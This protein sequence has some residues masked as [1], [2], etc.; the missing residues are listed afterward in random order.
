VTIRG[1]VLTPDGSPAAGATLYLMRPGKRM[2]DVSPPEKVA[3]T[4]AAGRFEITANGPSASVFGKLIAVADGHALE[5]A[6][7]LSPPAGELT[8]KLAADLPIRGRLLD[9]EGRPVAGAT[10]R[11]RSVD[12]TPDGDLSGALTA[13]RLNPEWVMS[14]LSKR[15]PAFPPPVR[16]A[17]KTDADG[18]FELR[19]LG[20]DRV[21]EL[22]FEGEGIESGIVFVVTDP[23]FDP[24]SVAPN[25][26]EKELMS[27]RLPG[28]RSAVYGP[29]FSHAARPCHPIT[30]TVRDTQTGAPI[31]G[32]RVT[33]SAGPKYFTGEPSW[34]DAVEATT[35]AAGRFRLNGL[36][37]AQFRSLHVAPGDAPYL[38]ALVSVADVDGLKPA[39]VEVKLTRC[40]LVTGRVTD[41][42]TGRPVKAQVHYE[43][44]EGNQ[45]PKQI[46]NAS[47][48]AGGLFAGVWP[49]GTSVETADDGTF[50]LRALSG[51][52]ALFVRAD[53]LRDPTAHYASARLTDA[54]RQQLLQPPPPGTRVRRTRHGSGENEEGVRC[55]G[56]FQP[57]RWENAYALIDPPADARTVTVNVALDPGR[58]VTGRLVGPDG[59]P[60]EGAKAVGVTAVNEY[61]PTT[62]PGGTFTA[63]ALD[64]ARPRDLFFVHEGRKLAGRIRLTGE[65]KEPVVKL[66]PWAAVTGRVVNPDGGPAANI[67]VAFQATDYDAHQLVGNKLYRNQ[68][69]ALT[70]RDGR[71][72]LEG[73]IPGL[74]VTVHAAP[75]GLAMAAGARQ[76]IA[77][78]AGETKDVGEMRLPGGKGAPPE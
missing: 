75:P 10:A 67:A 36:P 54:D 45:A 65:E 2:T 62:F 53:P 37:K 6:D 33:G 43:P 50:T 56:V 44:R 52:G 38:D 39:E 5:W 29:E 20:K 21:A 60:V 76:P 3:T 12:C 26:A 9:L 48:Y 35:D 70:D 49:S 47:I 8:L 22:V 41:R 27:K 16:A 42:Q 1:R 32:A 11:A 31:A 15:L 64:P 55:L 71:F 24:R 19:G 72:R 40:V 46:P 13:F 17:A 57:L 7:V 63:F 77:P 78:A 66:E 68:W 34:I 18:R 14:T 23:G 73:L 69:K 59:Q 28:Y 61:G 4:D 58:T 74:E 25:P 30:G 51:P